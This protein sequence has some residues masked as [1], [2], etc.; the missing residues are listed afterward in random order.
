VS[1][2]HASIRLLALIG[3]LAVAPAR[4]QPPADAPGTPPP[5]RRVV[6]HLEDCLG[7]DAA[8]VRRI[9]AAELGDLLVGIE[10]ERGEGEAAAV[11]ESADVVVAR[12][13]C[14]V[15]AAILSVAHAGSDVRFERRLDLA[16]AAPIARTRL[17]ALSIAE[18]IASTWQAVDALP[19]PAPDPPAPEPPGETTPE[20]A[21]PPPPPPIRAPPPGPIVRP[22]PPRRPVGIRLFGVGRIAGAPAHV[23]VGVGLGID[24]ALPLRL[25]VSGD[26]RYEQGTAETGTFGEARFRTATANLL[27][28]ARPLVGWSSV[29]IG[30]GVSVGLG[31]I[32]GVPD[33]D[34]RVGATHA[35]IFG[36]PVITGQVALHVAGSGYLHVGLEL[37]WITLQVAGVDQETGQTVASI[38]GA[39][40][41]VTAGFEIQPSR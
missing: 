33:D 4:A 37:G 28:L 29:S 13:E 17:L 5:A 41:A 12:A 23:S 6:L 25:A 31:W 1:G 21:P 8:A 27:A 20:P 19:P 24:V 3:N 39:Q 9:A 14:G 38:G 15:E 22:D 7:T 34:E 35:G 10:L 36:G 26:F 30:A 18:L 40:L 11:P 2:G 16:E 32:D